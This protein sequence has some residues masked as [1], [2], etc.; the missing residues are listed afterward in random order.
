IRGWVNH[1]DLLF[2]REKE[3][4]VKSVMRKVSFYPSVMRVDRLLLTMQRAGETLAAIVDEYGGAIGLVTMEDVAEEIVGE[5]EDE[6]DA[7][8]AFVRRVD[9]N[10]L[11]LNARIPVGQLNEILSERFPDGEYET[12]GGFMQYRLQKIPTE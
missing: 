12:L 2:A 1:Y 8:L 5:I 9:V 10:R 3:A 7:G 11:V 6:H 4:H